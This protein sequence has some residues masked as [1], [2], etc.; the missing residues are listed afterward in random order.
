VA[1]KRVAET[2][3]EAETALWRPD[4]KCLVAQG[5]PAQRHAIL[6]DP[7]ADIIAIGRDNLRDVLALKPATRPPFKTI[8]L[9]E[10]SGFKTKTSIRWKAAHR[11]IHTF[12]IPHVWGLTGTPAPNGL[13]DL[14]AQIALL[15][16]GHRL[17]KNLTTYRSRYFMPGRQLPNGVVIEYLLRPEAEGQI[18]HQIQDICLA[19]ATDG[20]IRLPEVTY[21]DIHVT[22]PP[23]TRQAYTTFQ[24]TLVADLRQIFAGEVHTAGNAATLTARL[25]QM[26]SGFIYVD[27]ADLRDYEFTTLHSAKIDALKEIVEAT[28]TPILCFYRFTAERKMIQAAL[29]QAWTIDEPDAIQKWNKQEIP[30]LLAHPASAGHG[31]NLQHGGHTIVWMSPTWDL[32]HWDQANK[33]LARQGQKHPVVIHSILAIKTIDQL[34]RKRLAEKSTV[35]QDLLAYLESPV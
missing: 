12:S 6:T 22:L 35:Q 15:D 5:S 23:Q 17:G 21:N 27:D 25:S 34:V 31:L 29:P 28:A 8:I 3:W 24:Q 10:L 32:E 26:T 7:R 33:R 13:L 19:M 1:P 18:R 9:D 30:L 11:I 16:D 2:V 14:W 4:L 20:R